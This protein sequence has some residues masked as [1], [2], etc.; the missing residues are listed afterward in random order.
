MNKIIW[1]KE[2][3]ISGGKVGHYRGCLVEKAKH[4]YYVYGSD[5]V[6]WAAPHSIM[7]NGIH[8]A[9]G[10]KAAIDR[11]LEREATDLNYIVRRHEV[12]AAESK[13]LWSTRGYKR[14]HLTLVG[15]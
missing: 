8:S 3:S 12:A 11:M 9:Q 13:R 6:S 7:S 1:T 10:A 15:A 2:V 14:C 4:F 5:H